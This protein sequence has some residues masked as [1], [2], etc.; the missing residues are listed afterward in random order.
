MSFVATSR[1]AAT[2]AM[3]LSTRSRRS[4]QTVPSAGPK[5]QMDAEILATIEARIAK[6]K[7]VYDKTHVSY[8]EELEEMWK[9]VKISIIVAAPICVLSSLKDIVTG[10]HHG[11]QEGELP[12]YMRIR[13]K[14][15]PWECEDCELFN[16]KCWAKCRAEKAAGN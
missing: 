6:Q 14:A 3:R 15:F 8:A 13:T 10:E 16:G 2:R 12:D 4:V 5:Q 1:L 9:W 11:R 7:Q